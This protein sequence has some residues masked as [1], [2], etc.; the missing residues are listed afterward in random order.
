M[1]GPQAD[2]VSSGVDLATL[3]NIPSKTW[4]T[5]CGFQHLIT[6]LKFP[7]ILKML[8]INSE[9]VNFGMFALRKTGPIC[10]Y[11]SFGA[12]HTCKIIPERQIRVLAGCFS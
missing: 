3:D 8:R 1:Q 5:F 12:I 11:T 4:R 7:T 9:L 6:V 10:K 2:C